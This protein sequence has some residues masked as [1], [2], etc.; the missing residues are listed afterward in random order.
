MRL[1][2]LSS[3]TMDEFGMKLH[4]EYLEMTESNQLHSL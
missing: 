3:K 4:K 2:I 1:V